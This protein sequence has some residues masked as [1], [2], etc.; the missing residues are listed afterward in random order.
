MIDRRRSPNN[1]REHSNQFAR[2]TW[3]HQTERNGSPRRR[4]RSSIALELGEHAEK[5]ATQR[6][7]ITSLAP[8]GERAAERRAN[9]IGL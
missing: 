7:K 8:R 1:V 5:R 3:R 2:E 6:S 4:R 9:R